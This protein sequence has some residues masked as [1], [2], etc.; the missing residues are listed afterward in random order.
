VDLVA[1]QLGTAKRLQVSLTI[2][3]FKTGKKV[4]LK[5]LREEYVGTIK[6]M[7]DNKGIYS[8]VLNAVRADQGSQLQ[9]DKVSPL[10]TGVGKVS[11]KKG[12]YRVT[13]SQSEG[14]IGKL[15][16]PLA[17]DGWAGQVERAEKIAS[18]PAEWAASGSFPKRFNEWLGGFVTVAAKETARL[19]AEK[20]A[21]EIERTSQAVRKGQ[22]KALQP[23]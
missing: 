15:T 7:L 23:A 8:L 20:L 17:F 11:D 1:C 9:V 4:M 19:A 16:L 12:I 21:A 6:A 2:G 5:A 22:E 13:V 14:Q 10:K 3:Q 18:F